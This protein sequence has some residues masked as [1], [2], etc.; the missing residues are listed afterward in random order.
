MPPSRIR[1]YIRQG[2]LA[3]L[4]VFEASARHGCYTRAARELHLAQP[5][6]SSHIRKLTDALG[7]PLFEQVGKRM[8]PTEAGRCLQDASREILG[9]LARLDETRASLRP[10]DSGRLAVAAGASVAP[11]ASRLVAHFARRYPVLEVGFQVCNRQALLERMG[12]DEDDLY[13]LLDPPRAGTVSQRVMPQ[14][15]AVIA[16]AAHPLGGRSGIAFEALAR[17][18]FVVRER[19]S[20]LRA[21]VDEAFRRR[22]LAPRVRLELPTHEAIVEAVRAGVGIAIVPL[23]AGLAP[24]GTV[25][26]DVQG[27][28]VEAH[29]HVCYVIGKALS[30]AGRA[31]VEFAREFR[32]N[33]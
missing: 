5:T 27:L 32:A 23:S 22:L 14:A 10:L 6:V 2:R 21:V 31:F 9:T 26:L 33:A 11:A 28:P 16:P 3:Q 20:G 25:M 12:R 15:F 30:P 29:L 13:L 8:H 17:E 7:V 24:D 19:G 1:R 4:A 18:P